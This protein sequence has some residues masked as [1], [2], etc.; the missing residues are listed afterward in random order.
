MN[1][2]MNLLMQNQNRQNGSSTPQNGNDVMRAAFLAMMSG[3]SPQEFLK[4]LPQCQG[5]DLSNLTEASKKLCQ[6]KGLDYEQTKA[7][8][9][10]QVNNMKN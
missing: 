10:N 1:P 2:L 9:V 7:N 5:I 4:T 8:V 3:Q 6:E